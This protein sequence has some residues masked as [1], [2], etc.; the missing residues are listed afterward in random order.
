MPASPVSGTMPCT[1]SRLTSRGGFTPSS[2]RI[3]RVRDAE[4]PPSGPVH[5]RYEQHL[6]ISA[7][8]GIQGRAAR[9]LGDGGRP[10]VS[11]ER[12]VQKSSGVWLVPP[13]WLYGKFRRMRSLWRGRQLSSGL[14]R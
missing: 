1:S 9:W 2:S 11:L 5:S 7:A 12:D 13:Q 10:L 6:R 4:K 8:T 3:E 14:G